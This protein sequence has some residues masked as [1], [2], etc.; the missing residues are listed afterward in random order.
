MYSVGG[1]NLDDEATFSGK[2]ANSKGKLC[3]TNVLSP[4]DYAPYDGYI[5]KIV[6]SKTDVTIIC[7]AT[8]TTNDNETIGNISW[9][10]TNDIKTHKTMCPYGGESGYNTVAYATRECNSDGR[11]TPDTSDCG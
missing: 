6:I 11:G 8:I 2:F 3:F 10:A 4:T 1:E 5:T 7:P 9:G